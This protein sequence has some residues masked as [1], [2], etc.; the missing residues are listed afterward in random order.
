MSNEIFSRCGQRCDLCLI[1][2]P[3]VEKED[4]RAEICAVWDKLGPKKYN[5]ATVICDGCMADGEDAVLFSGGECK[6][7]KCVI[8]KGLQHCGYCSDY[9][10]DIFPAEPNAD[11]FYEDMERRGVVWTANDDKMMEPY[12]PKKVIDEWR[13]YI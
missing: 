8:E 3:N 7:R 10:C 12:N 2:R 6:T 1:Y 13:K 4:R 11:E 9:P 5:P